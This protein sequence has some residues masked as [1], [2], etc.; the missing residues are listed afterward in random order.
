MEFLDII[1]FKSGQKTGEKVLRTEAH[2]K[3]LAHNA[4]HIWIISELDGKPHL[5]FQKRSFAKPNFPG[6][7]AATIG[8]HVQT[9]ESLKDVLRESKEELG[10]EVE[11]PEL[12]LVDRHPFT[13]ILGDYKD[14]EWI[15]EYYLNKNLE[16]NEYE[17]TDGEVIGL[18]AIPFE[19]MSFLMNEP[20]AEV[21][22]LY[23]DGKLTYPFA[24][25]R[26]HFVPYYF[27]TDLLNKIMENYSS[28]QT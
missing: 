2:Q 21:Q 8:G 1:D 5:L 22:S 10:I 26:S 18:C 12:N 16:L 23:F 24:L 14:Y 11:P 13:H 3:G 4:I 15:D 28:T 25:D 19:E 9:G 17:F 7:L 6:L 27:E 20:D